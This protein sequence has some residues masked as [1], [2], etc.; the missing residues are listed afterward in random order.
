MSN[1]S[2]WVL[3]GGCILTVIAV[4]AVVTSFVPTFLAPFI[5]AVI[6]LYIIY[7]AR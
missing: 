6:G 4:M 7:M 1:K 2:L 3:L 5:V